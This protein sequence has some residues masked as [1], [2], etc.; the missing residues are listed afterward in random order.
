MGQVASS[1]DVE[2]EDSRATERKDE[3]VE[4]TKKK[5]ERRSGRKI[6]RGSWETRGT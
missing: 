3:K 2:G 5:H 6:S 4:E 1:W